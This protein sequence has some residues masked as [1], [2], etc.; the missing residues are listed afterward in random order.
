[1][2]DLSF[3]LDA[4][5]NAL[6]LS[7]TDLSQFIRLEQCERYLRL[8]LFERAFTN[9]FM[10]DYGVR[11]QAIP[12]LLTRS[13]RSFEKQVEA[14][15]SRWARAVHL[16]QT[17]GGS[18]NRSPDNARLAEECRALA[19]GEVAV[20]FQTRI[21]A[22]LD[23]WQVTGDID[24]LRL[25]R[26]ADGALT[27]L[28]ADMKSSTTAKIDH[29]LQVAFYHVMLQS[30]FQ[31]E[32]IEGAEIRTGILYRG[33]LAH[34]PPDDGEP[35][36]LAAHREAARR[37][38]LGVDA[39]LEIVPDP[40]A[41]LAAVHD[42]VTGP[43]SLARRVAAEP[44][45][46]LPYHLTYKCDGCLYNEFCLK[47]SAERDDLSL[48]PHV[49]AQDKSALRRLGLH[50]I[51]DL[52]T[53]KEFPPSSAVN[54]GASANGTHVDGSYLVPAPGK[55][56]LCRAVATTWPVG[57][58]LDELVHR[59]RRYRKWKRDPMHSLS[60]I[61][62][63]GHGSLPY[64]DAT[65]NPNLIRVYIDAQHDYLQD[66]IYM[67]GA[68]VVACEAGVPARRRS[69]VEL[70]DG[71]PESADGEQHL[72]V[73]WIEATLRAIVELSAPDSAGELRAPIHLIFFNR[74]EQNLL[75]EALARHFTSILG[76]APALYEFM[77]Q[78]AAYDSPI[79]TFLDAEIRE[80]KNYSMTCQSLQAVAAYLRFNWNEPERFT[81]LFRE[82]M[83]DY[84]G[85][86]E[87][88]AGEWDWYA[89]RSRF[90][91]QIP[92]EY[93][94]AAWGELP[95]VADGERDDF[96]S[97]RSVTRD[98]LRRFHARR[99]E[100]LEAIAADFP[101]NRLTQ[102]TPFTLP[103]LS[104]FTDR[105][106]SLAQAL[107]EFVTI[108][109]AVEL[110]S[111]RTTRHAPPERR[112]LMGETLL[113][114]YLESDQEPEV[115][116]RNRDNEKRRLLREQ[117]RADYRLAH[118]EA[119]KVQLPPDQKAES[120][121]TPEGLRLRLRLVGEGLDCSLDEALAL[122]T[123]KSGDRLV[124]NPRWTT[125]ERLPPQEQSRFT[126]TPKQLLYGSRVDLVSFQLERNSEGQVSD[127]VVEIEW[128]RPSGST[129]RRGFYFGS[130]DRPLRDGEIYTL[131]PSPD[132]Y[133]GFWCAKITEGLRAIEAG[134]QAGHNT[135]YDRIAHPPAPPLAWPAEAIAAQERYLQGLDALHA[136][137]ELHSFEP[138]KREYIGEQGGAPILL[139]QGPPG[140]GK[141]YSTAFALFAR[142]QGA[143]A[144]DREFRVFVSCKTHAATDVLLSN[145]LRVRNE[146][147]VW[148]SKQPALF[149]RYF[150]LRILHVPLFRITPRDA[151][152][153]GIT[154]LVKD[155]EKP[156]GA[157]KNL[158]MIRG[159]RWCVV[160]ATPG[161]IYG[162]LKGPKVFEASVCDCLILDEASQMNLPEAAMAALPLSAHGQII[163]VGDHRQMPPIV[164]HDWDR[165]PRRTFQEY[166]AYESLFL[167]LLPLDPPIIR[168]EESF[169]L[170]ADMAHFLR[171]E[172]YEQDGIAY[173]S[174]QQKV[175]PARETPDPF[176]SA[177]LSPEHP[178]VVVVHD[179][180]ESQLR[181]PFEQSLITPLIEALADPERYGLDP[182]G[183]YGV[184]VPH[185]A[186]R[187]ALQT[188][189]PFLS[190]VDGETGAVLRSA[191]DTVERFQGGEREVILI[192][193]TESDREFLL[194]SS[195]FLLDPRRLTVAMSRAK[196]KLVLVAS[197]SVFSLFSP[198]EATFAKSLLWKNLLRRTCIV[199]LWRGERDDVSV[200]VWGN[201]PEQE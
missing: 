52:A 117:Y 4:T 18:A 60:E 23:P 85:K 200:E 139:V 120:D 33:S 38:V 3:S 59:A 108:E 37:Q 16:A 188:E 137:G 6:R 114:R 24:L 9:R 196:Q 73:R 164:Q 28:I 141:S 2:S 133:Y 27:V 92:L 91:S 20:L 64:A 175:L 135:L 32:G 190:V 110:G 183:G 112:V 168:F 87:G 81:E 118:P 181:N 173:F 125:D 25:E 172:I 187:A 11:P 68:L 201:A 34:V 124:L 70:A 100:A 159:E 55:E 105:A 40:D 186:Q 116:E 88:E 150:D 145:I 123:L 63:S 192:S 97:Y 185:R 167:S 71:P 49:T 154:P 176:V 102:K 193:A 128:A 119:A 57:P 197:R 113:V 136:A 157:P 132:S 26:R 72:L 95:P 80:R 163:V 76:A 161:G 45:E 194:A 94:Y 126:P 162:M 177:V 67:I 39:L 142:L 131:D 44:F 96:V 17:A 84:W 74:F 129:D 107:D 83:F 69:I 155:D 134:R 166:R 12:P 169:R 111:W 104:Q 79:A 149:A 143:M 58:R 140:T 86:L 122:S 147:C 101:G 46:T 36:P 152:P 153:D 195:H 31:E 130:M 170:H 171:R 77:T 191:V 14:D 198:D 8:R 156:K 7:P 13:G 78:L 29:R 115:A 62:H 89:A 103:D 82:R 5:G 75:L 48:L 53:L 180:A 146:L 158:A 47:W 98:H 41:Y 109:R 19:S 10:T 61:P 138:S 106:R 144:A 90:N 54:Q 43:S 199:P 178:I 35:D 22:A 50:R 65:Q 1:M 174:R 179:E 99:L 21:H 148:R 56:G 121:W 151:P 184:V 182:D 165:E 30:V 127:G 189:V 51:A 42:L 93:A 15:V 66:R 160:G